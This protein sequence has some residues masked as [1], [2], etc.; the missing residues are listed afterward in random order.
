M[1][2]PVFSCSGAV[3]VGLTLLFGG[4][5]VADVEDADRIIAR[6]IEAH[7]GQ[8]FEQSHIS[9]DFRG[10]AFSIARRNGTFRYERAL[11]DAEETVFVMTN[12][13]LYKTEGGTWV[14]MNAR[15]YRSAETALN[16]VVY[17]A[18]LPY[19]LQDEAAQSAL[20][21]V[22]TIAGRPYNRVEV[23]FEEEGGGRD[24]EDRF[25]YWFGADYDMLDFIAYEYFTGEGGTRF[26]EAYNRRDV[27]GIV[28][29]DY[30]NYTADEIDGLSA[31]PGLW[32][33][34]RLALVSTI[35]LEN[36]EVK[37]LDG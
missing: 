24:W 17:L 7:G 31:Y 30:R 29:Q 18:L 14:E 22:D 5:R 11:N 10:E 15:Q 28:F 20:L 25:M 23:T 35:E 4:C 12:D 13:S 21:G 32:L 9:F 36:I 37:L 33:R 8:R 16:S 2:T 34:D 3:L 6:A 27:E 26:R 19:R 1:Q